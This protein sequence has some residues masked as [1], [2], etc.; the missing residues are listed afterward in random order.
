MSLYYTVNLLISLCRNIELDPILWTGKLMFFYFPV[1]FFVRSNYT[2]RQKCRSFE[3][4]YM[5]II[6][7]I[8]LLPTFMI[9]LFSFH[10][11][12]ATNCSI[13]D[14]VKIGDCNQSLE[15]LDIKSN[16]SKSGIIGGAIIRSGGNLDLQGI[17]N[18]DITVSQGGSLSI[19]GNVNGE[20]INHGGNVTITGHVNKLTN[21][22]GKVFVYG[23]VD[24]STGNIDFKKGSIINGKEM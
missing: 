8:S 24:I 9:L 13:T 5:Q 20:V 21:V 19:H 3:S 11:T 15:F 16:I 1:N 14:G 2:Q 10:N 6:K 17:S 18:G 4:T 23:I 12:Y 22:Y 7:K